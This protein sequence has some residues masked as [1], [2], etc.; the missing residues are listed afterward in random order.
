[1]KKLIT[2]F[3][4]CLFSG[5]F[6]YAQNIPDQHLKIVNKLINSVENH[7]KNGVFKVLDKSYKNEQLKFL[8]GNKEQFLNELFS[9][10]DIVTKDYQTPKFDEIVSIEVSSIIA[11]KEG[12]YT[13]IFKVS[14]KNYTIYSTLLLTEEKKAGFVGSVG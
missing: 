4:L 1:M 12:G 11:L 5:T 9:G 6:L 14:T 10:E 7:K 2:A 3:I 8:K 13:Y